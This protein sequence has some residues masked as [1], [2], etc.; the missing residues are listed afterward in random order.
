MKTKLVVF[1]IISFLLGVNCFSQN[2]TIKEISNYLEKNAKSPKDYIISKFKQYDYVFLGEYHRVKH[3]VEFVASLVPHLYENDVRNIAFEFWDHTNQAFIDS[4]MTAKE[5]DEQRFY[6]GISKCFAVTWAYTEY[7]DILREIWRFNQ[8]LSENQ[9]KFRAVFA[10][11]EFY[12]CAEDPYEQ[13]GGEDP[14][15]QMATVFE[16]EVASKNE[17]ALIHCGIH[18]A[19]TSYHQPFYD[20]EAQELDGLNDE[21]FGNIIYEKY[22]KQSITVFL[23]SPWI[24]DKGFNKPY[25]KPVNGAI[26]DAMQLTGNK[27]CG[28]DVKN[29]VVGKLKADDTYYAFGYNDFT[30]SMFCDG[31]I[32]LAPMNEFKNVT[33][34]PNYFTKENIDKLK[35][36]IVCMGMEVETLTLE[37]ALMI[38]Q[39]ETHIERDMAHF[40]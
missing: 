32:F 4:M 31:Y 27:P 28:F 7:L 8:I 37:D 34:D 39:G 9:P 30:L 10:G 6:N 2:P 40:K 25:V 38:I 23:H 35:E 18:H 21:R 12:P 26:D 33:I 11:N 20:F 29:T 13:F 36:F 1:C 19:F 17:K 3:D 15:V 5:W 16:R 22:P 24:S 14:D